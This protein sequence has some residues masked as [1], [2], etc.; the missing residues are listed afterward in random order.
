[1]K[2]LVGSSFRAGAAHLTDAHF[3][4]PQGFEAPFSIEQ[5]TF[6]VVRI[7]LTQQYRLGQMP[8]RY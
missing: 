7:G 3:P 6:V 5:W 4:M 1:M 8:F 2:L